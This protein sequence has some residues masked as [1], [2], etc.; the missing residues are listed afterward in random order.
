MLEYR[1][2]KPTLFIEAFNIV[3]FND[4]TF[5]DSFVIVDERY[6]PTPSGD[7]LAVPIYDTYSIDY[8][9]IT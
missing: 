2:L 5:A 9:F 4:Q 8:K 7:S 1:I 3:R 6:E